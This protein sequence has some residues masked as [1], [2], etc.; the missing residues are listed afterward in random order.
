MNRKMNVHL[1]KYDFS[2]GDKVRVSKDYGTN[3]YLKI[4]KFDSNIVKLLKKFIKQLVK[5]VFRN[6]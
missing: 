1:S 5:I 6:G 4:V 3:P 2:I